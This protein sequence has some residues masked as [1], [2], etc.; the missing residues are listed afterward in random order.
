MEE[1]VTNGRTPVLHGFRNKQGKEFMA[2][3]V[4]SV[5]NKKVILE[6]PK[7]E[8]NGSKRKRNVPDVPVQKVR[9][10]TYKSGTVRLT[11]EGP[12]QFSS[13]VSFGVV[14]ARFAECHGLIAAAKLIKHYLQDLS[15]VHL[16]IS[17]NN[18]TFVEY[19]LKEKI[20][21]HLEDRS[22]MEHLWQ[23]L[24]EYGSWQIACEPRKSV[25]LKGGTSPVGF[26]RGLFPWLDPEVVETDEKI[27][28]KLPDC[29]AIRAQ[30][31][32]SIQKAVEEPGGSFA[33]PKAAK[34][35]LGAW[36]K[37]VRDAGKTG[38]EVVIQQP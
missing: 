31:K 18:R 26:P 6:F 13:S 10:E 4:V 5:D 22:L 20:P 16:Q 35:A 25:V 28:V 29:P 12:V 34:H 9:V 14:P 37:A 7:R 24:G 8:V 1:L 3:L 38:K 30:F 27:I 33:L 32:A 11:L 17:A 36:I 21:A 23:V 15:H 19:V 2:S